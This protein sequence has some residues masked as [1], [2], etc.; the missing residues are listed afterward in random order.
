MNELKISTGKFGKGITFCKQYQKW[1]ARILVNGRRV[2][3]GHFDSIEE[4]ETAYQN[5]K[6]AKE[7][8]AL[9]FLDI[10]TRRNR[11]TDEDEED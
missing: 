7:D 10:N 11:R 3:L 1:R 4:A 6:N 5:A 9:S 8:S 2:T